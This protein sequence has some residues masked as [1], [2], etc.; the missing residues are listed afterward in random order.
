MNNL[1]SNA[2]S[3]RGFVRGLAAMGFCAC[4]NRIFAGVGDGALLRFGVVSDVHVRLA[5][6]G[7]AL[8]AGYDTD[9]LEKTFAWYRDQGVDAVVIAGDMADT[10]LVGELKAVAD[11]WFR[12]FPNDRAPDGRKVERVF[13]FGNHD[14]FGL[15]RGNAV[16]EDEAV[17]R[18]EAID[19]DP[20][21]AW[22]MCFH[23][24]WQ[25]YSVKQVKGFSFFCSHWQPGVWCNGIAEAA[26]TGCGDAFRGL[27]EKCDPSKPFFYVQHPHP[28]DTVYGKG[29]WGIDDG[30]ATKLLS[31]FPQAVAFS[32]H[33]HEP[34]TNEQSIWR[35]AFTSVATGSLR[36]LCSNSIWANFY[37]KGYENGRCNYYLPGVK[38]S[39][40]PSYTA[41]YDAPKTMPIETTC[42]DIRVGQL[43]SVYEDRIVFA[44]R[45]FLSGLEIGED[46]VVELPARE[47]SFSVIGAAAKPAEFPGD[48]QLSV[49][50]KTATT[51]GMDKG[52]VKVPQE[53]V[54]AL[55][56]EFPAATIGG[57]VA[58]YEIAAEGADGGKGFVRICAI[59][60][61]YPRK[62]GKFAK[63]VSAVVPLSS[64]PQG[65]ATVTVTPLDSY[66]NRGRSLSAAIPDAASAS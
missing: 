43:V 48:A 37:T 31:Q 13:V 55:K 62:H 18:R 59:G 42:P 53:K 29:A 49:A 58:E 56:L 22:D 26:C 10:G 44:K 9:T 28:R 23:E 46:W 54:A 14:V 21:K 52:G 27:M 7:R 66:G 45:E 8:A 33:S 50:R 60:G 39:D 64:L 25:Q 30:S 36:Y 61:L 1:C 11:A 15:K 3:R 32:G 40:R 34:L 5:A 47:R 35:G 63:G 16:F 65:A 17:L 19:A 20:K 2:V 12:V 4:G 38:R 6:G 51:R 41:K 57:Q 24:E